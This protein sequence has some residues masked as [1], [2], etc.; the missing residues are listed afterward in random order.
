MEAKTEME[1]QAGYYAE[2]IHES[3]KYIRINSE[4]KFKLFININ[5][6]KSCSIM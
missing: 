5:S 1:T 3:R 4:Q 2:N 6:T